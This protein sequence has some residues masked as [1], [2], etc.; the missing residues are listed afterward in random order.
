MDHPIW[1]IS[2]FGGIRASSGDRVI[3]RFQT[4]KTGVLFAYLAYHV[5]RRPF[6][7]ELIEILWP[8]VE[9]DA[10][11]N[12]LSQALAWLRSVLEPEGTVKN[13]VLV[14]DRLSVGLNP[15]AVVT[16]V[17][18][19]QSAASAPSTQD[20]STQSSML[21]RACDLYVGHLLPG[22]YDDWVLGERQRLLDIHLKSL[23]RLIALS[24][25]AKDFDRAINFAR[26]AIAADPLAEEL[27]CELMRV[28]AA[29]GQS[30]AALREYRELER[31]LSKELSLTPSAGARALAEQIRQND[32]ESVAPAPS[33]SG[34]IS[35]IPAP[36]NR[37]FGRDIEIGQV[38]S[39]WE[40]R[41]ARLITLTG[42][43]GSGKT[44]LAVEIASRMAARHPGA[45]AIVPLADLRDARLVPAAVADRL[46]LPRFREGLVQDQLVA[47]LGQRDFLLVLDNLEHLVDGVVLFIRQMLERVPSL[48]ILATSQTRL[49]LDGEREIPVPPL[50]SPRG[51]LQKARPE[52]LMRL[53]SVQLFVD[54]AQA[55]RSDFEID[56]RN[57]VDIAQICDRLEG[58][59]LAIEL[60]AA[61]AQALSPAQMLVQLDHRFDLLVSRRSDSEPRHRSLHAAVEHSYHLISP[62]LQV[63]FNR[64]SVFRGGWTLEA[65]NAIV[66]VKSPGSSGGQNSG[67]V[68]TL[69]Q[70]MRLR[71]RSLI[72]T[73]E[74]G[75]EMRY[76]MLDTLRDF[77]A[78]L[79]TLEED[80]ALRRW[81]AEFFLAVAEEAEPRIV[82]PDQAVW[83]NRLKTEHDNFRAALAWSIDVGDAGIA[84]R[85][86]SA[87]APFW[88]AHG[89]LAEGQDW[90]ARVTDVPQPGTGESDL[91]RYRARALNAW[92][93][94]ARNQGHL[95]RVTAA[96]EEAL[97]TWRDLGDERG[98]AVTLQDLATVA[99]SGDDWDAAQVYLEEA[100][101]LVQKLGDSV[102]QARAFINLGNLSLARSEWRRAREAYT[103]GLKRYGDLGDRIGIAS[104]LNNLGLL[105][106][107]EGDLSSAITL[108]NQ[109]LTVARELS[110]LPGTA[111]SLLN[112]AHVNRIEGCYDIARSLIQEGWTLAVDAGERRLLPECLY[113]SGH[114]AVAEQK[115]ILAVMLLAAGDCLR[116]AIGISSGPFG[117]KELEDAKSLARSVLGDS[118][119]EAA[120]SDGCVLSIGQAFA[121]AVANEEPVTAQAHA[122]NRPDKSDSPE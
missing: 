58:I 78:R 9:L 27:Y 108:L 46:Q 121:M 43:V 4:Q 96:L 25:D 84:L 83:L 73:E 14:S 49:G 88:N 29:S 69:D 80:E 1:R 89:H 52:D 40:A 61:W 7:E 55:V 47:H 18:E 51:R 62:D 34:P 33:P 118:A 90:L 120:W 36:L 103:E 35:S 81:H 97:S 15:D 20:P 59:P 21:T 117:V 68:S 106:I 38:Q 72:L 11:R 16:D 23:R 65:A 26:R 82:G 109:S 8:D 79:R 114:V 98:I 2:L 13:S 70:L 94:L 71:D 37:F 31:V 10:G 93:M 99:Y 105:G 32:L 6:R 41:S 66:Q 19:F 64:L 30:V 87:L 112:L 111:V 5:Q 17:G 28:L 76:R 74:S 91:R 42:V 92:G 44:R 75:P 22:Y 24:E 45:V 57:A 63:F 53:T 119:F 101:A 100:V 115:Y 116:I 113:E 39:L 12:R 122:I 56:V 104:A 102:L 77:A 67:L 48:T 50:A 60:C 54:R 86:A 85:L 3:D 110:N 107:Y 95:P